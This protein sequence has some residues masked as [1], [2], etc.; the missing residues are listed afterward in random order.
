MGD[1]TQHNLGIVVA[2][3]PAPGINAVIGA[4][5]IEARNRGFNVTG[6]YD[7]FKWLTDDAFDPDTH[8]TNLTIPKVAR[9]HFDGGSMLRI[10]RAS[11]LDKKSKA[12][13]KRAKPDPEK[14][15]RI[16]ARLKQ[17]NITHLITIGGDDTALSAR[18]VSEADDNH[19]RIAHVP[20]TIDNDLPLPPDTNTFGFSTARYYGTQ[21]VKNL[22]QDSLTTGRWYLVTVMGRTAGFLAHGIGMSASA[23]ATLI[24]EE[25][26]EKITVHGIADVIEGAML[27]RRVMGRHDGVVVVAEGLAGKL[28]DREELESMLGTELPV[29]DAG[30]IRLANIPLGFLLRREIE[31]RFEA[32]GDSI[33]IVTH[34]LGY[35]LRSADP[36]PNDMAYCRTLGHGAV[37]WLL[38]GSQAHAGAM[39][40]VHGGELHPIR[41][42]DM[43][44]PE[45]NRIR[46]RLV[47]INSHQYKV[48]RSYMLRL[49][50]SDL[51][52]SETLNKLAVAAKTNPDDFKTHYNRAATRLADLQSVF[53]DEI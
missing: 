26:P 51:Q 22:M 41:F 25:F 9:I 1:H 17:L 7:G 27:K 10:S 34:V 49:E 35:E 36:T 14:V 16:L 5:T 45:T 38:T 12:E 42:T 15:N 43:I 24:P 23:T 3:G 19:L 40:T 48:A 30:H 32:R 6:F 53:G 31:R 21:I 47:D 8:T 13:G 33:S 11:L 29:D 28:G 18:F 4:A 52:D 2:G 39:I 20:K 37:Q 50:Q 44:D 46:V